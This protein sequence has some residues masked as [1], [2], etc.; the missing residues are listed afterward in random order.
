MS[1]KDEFR[2]VL[3]LSPLRNSSTATT[4]E[5]LVDEQLRHFGIDPGSPGGEA[6]ARLVTQLGE[7]NCAAHELWELTTQT[8][9]RLDRADAWPET[10][11]P[12]SWRLHWRHWWS[13]WPP[14]AQR[15]RKPRPR[16]RP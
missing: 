13:Q 5:E 10:R 16:A 14:Q 11:E 9:A 15:P 4:P 6:L 7:A 3:Q 8:L 2:H 12:A 1:S